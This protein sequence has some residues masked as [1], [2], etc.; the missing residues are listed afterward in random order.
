FRVTGAHEEPVRPGVEARRVAETGKVLPDGEQRLLRRVLGEVD[1]AQDPAR[2]GKE[3]I[4]DPG[5]NQPE[6]RL[7]TVLGEDHEVGIH[8]SFLVTAAASSS[9]R[10]PVWAADRCSR[11]TPRRIAG[12]VRA[13]RLAMTHSR[14]LNEGL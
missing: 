9:A 14:V 3:S 5:G 1:V 10:Q 12:S 6:G 2:D 11:V 7:V 13:G 8:A 4:R